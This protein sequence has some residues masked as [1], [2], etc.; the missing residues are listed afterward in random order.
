[1][2]S[3]K[4]DLL[5]KVK[6]NKKYKSISDE[7]IKKEIDDYFI[8]NKITNITKQDI[9]TIR[10]IFHK[11][12]SSFQTRHKKKIEKYF[13]VLKENLGKNKS[14]EKITNDLLSI[15]LSTKERL[16]DYKY[17]YKKIFEKTITPKI[18]VDLG[19]GFN[20]FS[21][22]FMN[23]KNLE[24][25]SYDINTD[26]K[27][28]LNEY[29]KIMKLRGLNGSAEIL[30]LRNLKKISKIPNSDII[31]LFKVFDVLDKENHKTS[32]E[33]IK[34]LTNKTK[35]IVAS[36]AKKTLTRKKMNNPNRLW[37]E[38]MLSRIGLS[39]EKFS[40]D[41]EIF[42]VVKGHHSPTNT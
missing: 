13:K 12:Y 26:D 39:F 31:F 35:Y 28:Y 6:E 8:K 34:V 17:I 7:I 38:L 37:F 4:K 33:L 36:F 9:K 22:P 29:F 41:N 42:Y 27:K 30:D 16:P 18:I 15:T 14:I 11:S 32:E 24:Y 23:L 20:I 25:H 3:L 5:S 40:T 10:N 2:E 1:M 21:Y 19:S